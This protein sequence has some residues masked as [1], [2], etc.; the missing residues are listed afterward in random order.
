MSEEQRM[1]F[2][3]LYKLHVLLLGAHNGEH[4]LS[5]LFW[6]MSGEERKSIISHIDQRVPSVLKLIIDSLIET[7]AVCSAAPVAAAVP[8]ARFAFSLRLLT[9]G[10]AAA[11]G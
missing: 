10:C 11:A 6:N 9:C 8:P 7:F 3:S 4:L 2:L 5:S 1:V